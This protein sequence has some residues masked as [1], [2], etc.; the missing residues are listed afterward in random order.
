METVISIWP[1]NKELDP[2]EQEE[3]EK[4][5]LRA[6]MDNTYTTPGQSTK[7]DP[8]GYSSQDGDPGF[9]PDEIPF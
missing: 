4:I 6:Y 2:E 1:K 9:N 8:P 3:L 5:D 7:S